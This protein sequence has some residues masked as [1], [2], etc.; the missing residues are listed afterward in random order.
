M[1]EIIR[2]LDIT[3]LV[4]GGRGIGRHDG[5]AVFVPLT[6]PG[7]RVACRIVKSKKRYLEAELYEII[8]PSPLRREPPCPFFGSCGGCQWQHLP[9]R[10]QVRWKE[11]IFNDLLVRSKVISSDRLKLIVPAP[12][13]WDYRNRVQFKCHLTAK[14]LVVGF[15]RHGSHFVVDI[16]RCR[17]VAPPIQRV[18]NLL[19]NDLPGAPCPDCITQIDV[20][21]GDDGEARIILHVSSKGCQQLRPWLQAF[22]GRHQLNVCLQSG[23]RKAPEV[24]CGEGDLTIKVD[25]PEIAL[26]YGPGGFVQVNSAQN[27]N[28]IASMLELLAL[29][30]TENVLDLFCG[31]GNFS[32]PLARRAGRVTG[33]EDYAPSIARA[34]INAAANNIDNV[35]FHATDASAIM[36]NYPTADDLDL[37]LLDPPRTGNYQVS[38]EL[39]KIRPERI[40]YVS[41]DPATLVRDLTPLVHNGYEVVSSQ[42]FD[43]FP[44]TW[45][46]ESMTLLR[47]PSSSE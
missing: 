44:Q 31:M 14:G 29:N 18:F 11:N 12:N 36:N 28:M 10:E 45:H 43:L 42:P 46:I 24:V 3:S 25:Q 41:C 15:Y 20:A 47:N 16:D 39:L 13:E 22:A 35:E 32:L 7:D 8:D 38:H 5:K 27:R 19:R 30:G 40:L 34:R 9:Y 2:S 33:V 4:H 6:M 26:R 17:L 1:P 37:V 21:C 23:S